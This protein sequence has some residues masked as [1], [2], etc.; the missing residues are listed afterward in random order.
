MNYIVF[1]LE[2]NAPSDLE[3]KTVTALTSEIVE[4]GAVKL[5]DRFETVDEFR[6]FIKPRFFPKMSRKITRLTGVYDKL[7]QTE[8]LPFP[9]AYRKFMDWC[10]DEIIF[11]T[12]SQSDIPVLAENMRAYDISAAELPDCADVQRV[13]GYE[14]MR[15]DTQVSLDRALSILGKKGEK[16]HD[17]LNDAKN[18]VAVCDHMDLE[19]FI[20][21]Y[22]THYYSLEDTSAL[23]DDV[24]QILS[25]ESAAT[26]R[27]PCCGAPARC[28]DWI[29]ARRGHPIS[30]AVCEEG[31]E[32][33]VDLTWNKNPDGKYRFHRSLYAM[34]DDLWDRYCGKKENAALQQES[35]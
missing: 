19:A 26:F 10:G 3:E 22:I 16:A 21:E 18:T 4:I 33:W 14:I 27:C 6:V 29:T 34:N 11:L 1:D 28:E 17:A 24:K 23:Y 2:W 15:S 31:D 8:G 7:L 32:F 12:W 13:F 30:Y 5:N 9:D 35:T 20:G 25:D